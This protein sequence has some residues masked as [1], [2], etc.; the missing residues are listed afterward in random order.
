MCDDTL[1]L[2]RGLLSIGFGM[3]DDAFICSYSVGANPTPMMLS[4]FCDVIGSAVRVLTYIR[5]EM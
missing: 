3:C 1:L 5:V 4:W 2:D